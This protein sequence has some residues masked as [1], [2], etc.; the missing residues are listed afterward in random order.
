MGT[1][2]RVNQYIVVDALGPTVHYWKACLPTIICVIHED[3]PSRQSE[4]AH[5]I[6]WELVLRS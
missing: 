5:A 2:Q 3:H 1:R 4:G 6:A